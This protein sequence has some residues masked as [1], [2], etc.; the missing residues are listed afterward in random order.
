MIIDALIAPGAQVPELI[1]GLVLVGL[2]QFDSMIA[3]A[4]ERWRMVADLQKDPR[5]K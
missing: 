4:V 1:V 3:G 5:E 2:V